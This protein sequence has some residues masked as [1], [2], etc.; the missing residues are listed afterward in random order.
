M[1]GMNLGRLSAMLCV[2]AMCLG[3]QPAAAQ[4]YYDQIRIGW[5]FRKRTFVSGGVYSRLKKLSDGSLAC[6][7]SEGPGVYIRKRNA[8]AVYQGVSCPVF[9]LVV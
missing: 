1:K 8:D 4:T 5:D 2:A 9:Y 3:V 7:Y 6:V